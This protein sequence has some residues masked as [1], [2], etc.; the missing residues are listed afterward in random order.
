M[1]YFLRLV[2]YD[3]PS[4]DY[5]FLTLSSSGMGIPFMWWTSR[6]T[7]ASSRMNSTPQMIITHH[8]LQILKLKLCICGGHWIKFV[9]STVL[10][11]AYKPGVL[12]IGIQLPGV[13]WR[14][15]WGG[16][17]YGKVAVLLWTMLY[18]RQCINQN[19]VGQCLIWGNLFTSGNI[20]P[21]VVFRTFLCRTG[22]VLLFAIF[23]LR[24]HFYLW[25]IM[26]HSWPRYTL[27]NVL[28]CVMSYSENARCRLLNC[29]H[30]SQKF[31]ISEHELMKEIKKQVYCVP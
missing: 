18:S 27:S 21:N 13:C 11:T 15:Y 12:K 26:F 30:T 24:Q 14:Y 19:N 4:A 23:Y 17:I 9:W 22:N 5:T 16:C 10:V 7:L 6:N 3:F 2:K 8:R 25:G 31:L 20:L 29:H 28:H 1:L